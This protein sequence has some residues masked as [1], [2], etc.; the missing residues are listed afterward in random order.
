MEPGGAEGVV[1]SMDTLKYMS[2]GIKRLCEG[3]RISDGRSRSYALGS[4]GLG[5]VAGYPNDQRHKL[6][7]R[8]LFS[9]TT[10]QD[11]QVRSSTGCTVYSER[12]YVHGSVPPW[13]GQAGASRAHRD[14]TLRLPA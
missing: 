8:T 9:L 4:V 3:W 5:G 6:I 7:G 2:P 11:M 10:P 1:R 12:A 13:C 14:L